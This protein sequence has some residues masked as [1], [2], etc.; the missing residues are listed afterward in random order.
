MDVCSKLLCISVTLLDKRERL[1]ESGQVSSMNSSS[2]LPGPD[3][4]GS[5]WLMSL[6]AN[7]YI[8]LFS[9]L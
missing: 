1:D 3:R 4:I 5:P 9:P 7:K 6:R 2:K 8:S